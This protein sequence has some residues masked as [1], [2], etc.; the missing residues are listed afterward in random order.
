M[1]FKNS[2]I[3]RRGF[4]ILSSSLWAVLMA[5]FGYHAVQGN[6]GLLARNAL[7]TQVEDARAD[8]VELQTERHRLEALVDLMSPETLDRDMLDER[9]RTMLNYAHPD[10]IV[11]FL[12][13]D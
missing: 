9:A 7:A 8:L 13:E 4:A 1:M 5:Y 6:H 10:D 11:I 2:L 3:R 12:G